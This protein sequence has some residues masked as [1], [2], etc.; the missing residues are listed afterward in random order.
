MSVKDFF[1]RIIFYLTVPKCVCCGDPLDIREK[2]LCKVCEAK[3]IIKKEEKCGAC[4]KPY[5]ECTC[6]NTYL[7]NHFVKKLLKLFRYRMPLDSSEPVPSNEL[8][9]NLKRT[10]R[11]DLVDYISSELALLIKRNIKDY[12]EFIITNVPRNKS[13]VLK[14]GHDHSALLAKKIADKLGIKY[15]SVLISKQTKAQKKTSGEERIS[16]AVFAYKRNAKLTSRKVFLVD[17]IVTTGASL[18]HSAMLLRGLNA[19]YIV[20][21]CMGIAF[22]DRT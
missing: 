4:L 14:Y 21:V 18:G 8:V 9:Y 6:T 11:D 22:R 17:D 13:R 7:K 5:G 20:G 16:N 3:H 12:S 1:D 10:Y 19:K 15:V 2:A